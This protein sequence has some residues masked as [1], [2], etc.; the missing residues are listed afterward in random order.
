MLSQLISLWCAYLVVS[1]FCLVSLTASFVV[2]SEIQNQV[3]FVSNLLVQL[4]SF[5]LKKCN[6][7]TLVEAQ[8]HHIIWCWNKVEI[9]PLFKSFVLC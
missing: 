2:A 9:L 4:V 8:H 7:A 5:V 3:R 6:I 1:D